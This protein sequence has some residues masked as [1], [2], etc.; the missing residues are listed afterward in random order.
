MYTC[1]IMFKTFKNQ[2]QDDDRNEF[3]LAGIDSIPRT[4]AFQFPD[5]DSETTEVSHPSFSIISDCASPVSSQDY[6]LS[7]TT[8]SCQV[9]NEMILST[10]S[11]DNVSA[12]FDVSMTKVSETGLFG[13]KIIGDNIDKNVKPRNYRSNKQVRSLHYYHSYALRDRVSIAEV[14]DKRPQV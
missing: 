1:I 11:T 3:Q 5:D 2:S 9:A 13:F 7:V 12:D 4:D 14:S 10:H 6:E 8:A